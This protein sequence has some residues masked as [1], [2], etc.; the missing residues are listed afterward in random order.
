VTGCTARRVTLGRADNDSLVSR[1]SDNE[2]ARIVHEA[3]VR[4][5]GLHPSII[6]YGHVSVLGR[7]VVDGYTVGLPIGE[8][9]TTK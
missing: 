9:A 7:L 1:P 3:D 8:V 2:H 5:M 4:K 6:R